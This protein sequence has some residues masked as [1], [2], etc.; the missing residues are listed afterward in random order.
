MPEL[1]RL[2][3]NL[4]LVNVV[5]YIQSGNVIFD[6]AEHDSAE[7]ANSIEVEIARSFGS[8][9]RVLVRDISQ[10]QEIFDHNP[11]LGLRK[12]VPEKLYV[13][14]LSSNPGEQ[15]LQKLLE[16][17]GDHLAKVWPATSLDPKAGEADEFMVS[18]QVIYLFCP[19]G[20]GRTKLSNSFFERLLGV[21]ATT[22]NW[23][24]V[25][26]LNEIAHQRHA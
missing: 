25:T 22:R 23:K 3:E 15:G 10:L 18:D 13:T 20:Y 16:R 26:A 21:P 24:T 11:F 9:V 5:T 2:F 6:C 8:N 4:N 1:R 7:L 17:G 19:N 12:G 14:F